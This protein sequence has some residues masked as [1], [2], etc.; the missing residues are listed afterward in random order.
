VNL[1]LRWDYETPSTERYNRLIS[2]FDPNA[3]YP[4]GS[5]GVVFKGG[6]VYANSVNRFGYKP[7]K[8]NIQPRFGFAYK[9]TEKLVLR[10]GYGIASS[11]QLEIPPTT[12]F[13]QTTNMVTSF[14]Q[15]A[16]PANTLS[17]P[18]PD[19]IMRPTGNTLGYATNL[20]Q[21]VSYY[22]ADR[23]TPLSQSFSFG[24]QYELPYQ[25][26]LNLSYAGE[27]MNKHQPQGNREDNAIPKAQWIA[28]GNSAGDMVPNPYFGL[29]PGTQLNGPMIPRY[30]LLLPYPQFT[31]VG[32][33]G[34]T[35]GKRWYDAMQ[36]QAEKRLSHGLMVIFNYTFSKSLGQIEYL[37]GGHDAPDEFSKSII[38]P[39]RQHVSNLAASYALPFAANT[40]GVTRQLLYG[41]NVS[42]TITY[43]SGQPLGPLVGMDWTGAQIKLDNSTNQRYFNTCNL[44]VDGQRHNCASASEPI[45]WRILGPYGAS[46]IRQNPVFSDQLRGPHN[47][48]KSGVSAAFFKQFKIT[49]GSKLELRGEFF[50]LFNTPAFTSLTTMPFLPTFGVVDARQTNEPRQGQL[51]LRY[52]F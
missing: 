2:G 13:S 31:S 52:S 50:N 9:V 17:N 3:V 32:R 37:N 16:T 49:E 41:W 29:F 6:L 45:A 22:W 19:G 24:L 18:Y 4:V 51:S 7:D 15:N 26:V 33:S 44:G 25:T 1:G 28:L 35:A 30:Q 40:S 14:D 21:G 34:Y 27:R 47:P 5:N 23:E 8:N 12:G 20:G 36:L 43:Q 10:G 48:Y 42:T 39:D 11:P 46:S 38:P